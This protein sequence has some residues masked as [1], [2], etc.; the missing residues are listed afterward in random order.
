MDKR[1]IKMNWST[2]PWFAKYH[3]KDLTEGFKTWWVA[4]Y[5][6]PD[7]YDSSDDEQHEYWVRCSF[8]LRGWLA[9][10]DNMYKRLWRVHK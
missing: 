1:R 7:A 2:D 3:E 5:G 4:Y 10:K 9:F 6:F 8:A